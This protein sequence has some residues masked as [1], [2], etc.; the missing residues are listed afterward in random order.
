MT[1]AQPRFDRH[2]TDEPD[3]TTAMTASQQPVGESVTGIDPQADTG[4]DFEDRSDPAPG[5]PF[6]RPVQPG[7]SRVGYDVDGVSGDTE[8]YRPD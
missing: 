1:D 2:P 6:H 5:D 8:A 3:G 7:E 4:D